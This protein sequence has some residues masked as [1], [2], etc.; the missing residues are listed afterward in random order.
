MTDLA[1][2]L[3]DYVD[4]IVEPITLEEA[5][6]SSVVETSRSQPRSRRR[7]LVGAAVAIAALAATALVVRN[8]QS[9]SP[10]VRPASSPPAVALH[11]T[12]PADC[13]S[14]LTPD[15]RLLLGTTLDNGHRVCVTETATATTFFF[16][17]HPGL[18]TG[19]VDDRISA[20]GGIGA[21]NG[22]LIVAGN[23]PRS[24]ARLRITF[25]SGRSLDVPAANSEPPR[26]VFAAI[27]MQRA[28]N[29]RLLQPFD[30]M[31]GAVGTQSGPG[32]EA[33]GSRSRTRRPRQHDPRRR[34]RRLPV[35]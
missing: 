31:G 22:D 23:I 6:G 30:L 27:S 9:E 7:M 32:F 12:G 21:V 8:V 24:A 15:S 20:F 35:P 28:D 26:F 14:V 3:R 18:T 33:C 25:C 5:T 34:S 29:I 10:T 19:V 2:S 4:G 13:A 11:P 16:D 1:E 17:G